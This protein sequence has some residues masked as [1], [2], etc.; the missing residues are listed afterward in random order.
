MWGDYDFSLSPRSVFFDNSNQSVPRTSGIEILFFSR[1][2]GENKS[3]PSVTEE[4][5]PSFASSR[6]E[7][8]GEARPRH[9]NGEEVGKVGGLVGSP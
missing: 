7:A 8:R 9:A 5:C 6:G 3:S 1:G 2:R 4:R